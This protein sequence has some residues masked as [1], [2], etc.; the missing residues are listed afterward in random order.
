MSRLRPVM[1][2]PEPWYKRPA[3]TWLLA[4]A[5]FV[6]TVALFLQNLGVI[7]AAINKAFGRN[8]PHLG[9]INQTVQMAKMSEFAPIYVRSR[10]AFLS[11]PVSERFYIIT[12]FITKADD[13]TV[14]DCGVVVDGDEMNPLVENGSIG[15]LS[16]GET[17]HEAS[18]RL[19]SRADDPASRNLYIRCANN[20]VSGSVALRLR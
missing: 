6:G 4:G 5:A 8:D 17:T 7:V 2:A 13:A 14:N 12:F 20:V 11:I 15:N 18:F 9:I 1:R 16:Q 19:K 3:R 10:A